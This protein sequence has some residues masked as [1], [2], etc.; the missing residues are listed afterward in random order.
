VFGFEYIGEENEIFRGV[1]FYDGYEPYEYGE[2]VESEHLNLFREDDRKIEN[3]EDNGKSGILIFHDFNTYL[4]LIQHRVI[5]C[6]SL[7]VYSYK[8]CN[9]WRHAYSMVFICGSVF[10]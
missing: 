2:E 3:N 7:I 10:L 5:Q 4:I 1:W 9:F 6:F 8:R